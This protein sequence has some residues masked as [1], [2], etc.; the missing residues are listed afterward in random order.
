MVGPVKREYLRKL[1]AKKGGSPKA[2]NFLNM[3]RRVIMKTAQGKYIVRTNKGVSYNPKAK[4]YKNP[5]GSTVATKYVKN[6]TNIPSPIRPKFNRRER[7]NAGA[8]RGKYAPRA[9]GVR[10]LPVKRRAYITE[11]EEGH[12]AKRGRGRPRKVRSP[13][14]G[15]VARHHAAVLAR[16]RR[17]AEKRAFSPMMGKNLLKMMKM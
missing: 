15:P 14:P 12:P 13:R 9:G 2:T 16:K 5:A 3:K 1:A 4:F 7:K 6:L 8:A 10:V 17:L 11:L